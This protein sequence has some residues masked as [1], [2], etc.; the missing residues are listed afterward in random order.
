MTTHRGSRKKDKPNKPNQKER[1]RNRQ[2][3][4]RRAAFAQKKHDEALAAAETARAAARWLAYGRLTSRGLVV[5]W[6]PWGT[7]VLRCSAV[8]EQRVV[9]SAQ[10]VDQATRKPCGV[11]ETWHYDVHNDGSQYAFVLRALRRA[12]DVE[13]ALLQAREASE[14]A[15]PPENALVAFL[16]DDASRTFE[17]ARIVKAED[18]PRGVR[19]VVREH[20]SAVLEACATFPNDRV[21]LFGLD[22]DAAQQ[23]SVILKLRGPRVHNL[24][25]THALL[26]RPLLTTKGKHAGQVFLDAVLLCA[27]SK[28]VLPLLQ[29][30]LLAV[31][32]SNFRF[33]AIDNDKDIKSSREQ[34]G[35][36]HDQFDVAVEDTAPLAGNAVVAAILASPPC[37]PYC[38]LADVN[39]TKAFKKIGSYEDFAAYDDKSSSAAAS[40][41]RVVS[42]CLDDFIGRG[43]DDDDDGSLRIFETAKGNKLHRESFFQGRVAAVRPTVVETSA[44]RCGGR[45]GNG[46]VAKHSYAFYCLNEPT[47][48]TNLGLPAACERKGGRNSCGFTHT[49]SRGRCDNGE[50][51]TASLAPYCHVINEALAQAAFEVIVALRDKYGVPAS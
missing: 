13:A 28:G 44:C 11:A 14:R 46:N 23:R 33:A 20:D 37:R 12:A 10:P 29:S 2:K 41:T 51:V 15:A 27:G 50:A 6:R 30:K 18:A 40:A 32:I 36:P 22:L 25:D 24:V 3:R 38:Q 34:R 19:R 26:H 39:R 43:R 5:T 48:T 7:F 1:Q 9:A 16:V 35:V 4:E 8:D 21:A 31:G 47:T 42:R 45:D 17:I 49:P